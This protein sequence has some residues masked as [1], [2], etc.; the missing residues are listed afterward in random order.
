MLAGLRSHCKLK[1]KGVKRGRTMFP[2][3]E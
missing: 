1:R 3:A 2:G